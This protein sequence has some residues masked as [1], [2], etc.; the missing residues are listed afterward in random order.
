MSNRHRNQP[1]RL[2]AARAIVANPPALPGWVTDQVSAASR[3]ARCH[4]DTTATTMAAVKPG[5]LTGAGTQGRHLPRLV[6]ALLRCEACPHV[7]TPR[8]V[9]VRLQLHRVDCHACVA[10]TLTQPPPADEGDACDICGTRGHA[11]FRETMI[12]I[13]L[14][15]IVGN[16]AACCADIGAQP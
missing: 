14:A 9:V 12:Q 16:A 1:G 15:L 11:R 6:A 3:D 4:F 10:A 5:T 2:A 13:G 8:P 7:R